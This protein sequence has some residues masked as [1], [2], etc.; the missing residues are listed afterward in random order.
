MTDV[1]ITAASAALATGSAA[2]MSGWPPQDVIVW[3]LIGGLVSVWMARKAEASL[4]A[5]FLAAALAQVGVSA[6]A[7]IALSAGLLALAPVST[8]TASLASV[9]RWVLA[10]VIAAVIHR[11]APLAMAWLQRWAGPR[12]TQPGDGHAE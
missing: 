8:W 4:T 11:A 10:G 12:A 7:G 6:A 3:A 5:G 1:P 2:A 9:P